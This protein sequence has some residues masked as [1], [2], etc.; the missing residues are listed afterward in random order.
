MVLRLIDD[1]P[2]AHCVNSMPKAFAGALAI[3]YSS[4]GYRVR[5]IARTWLGD[6]GTGKNVV[7]FG[8][9]CDDLIT[10]PFVRAAMKRNL[11]LYAVIS[12]D[13]QVPYSFGGIHYAYDPQERVYRG[14]AEGKEGY[15]LYRPSPFAQFY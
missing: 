13:P 2:N 3:H 6:M 7:L 11:P 14:Q 12:A 1:I 10:E 9:H 4:Y 5:D 15:F 8:I